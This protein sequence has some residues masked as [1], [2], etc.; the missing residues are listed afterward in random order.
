MKLLLVASLDKLS[1]L[2][3]QL[4]LPTPES[5]QEAKKPTAFLHALVCL[6][7]HANEVVLTRHEVTKSV[8]GEP[9]ERLIAAS[10][11]TNIARLPHPSISACSDV[12][13]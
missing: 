9:A 8:V 2:E 5:R 11:D 7:V 10:S 4:R 13:L 3:C 6:D 1:K 12:L